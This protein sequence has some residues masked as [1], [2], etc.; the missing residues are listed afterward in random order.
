MSSLYLK[1]LPLLAATVACVVYYLN[2]SA[3]LHGALQHPM[4]RPIIAV[5]GSNGSVGKRVVLRA[6]AHG[7]HVVGID[8]SPVATAD[9]QD[10][11]EHFS[12]I[13][14]DLT[15]YNATLSA[16]A[17]AEAII[18]LAA[19]PQP[20]DYKTNT[21]NTNVVSSYNVLRAAAELGIKRVAQASTVNVVTLVFSQK[22]VL[23]YLPIDEEHL[24]EPDEPYGLSKVIAELQAKSIVRRYPDMRVASIRLHWSVPNRTYAN[25]QADT[26]NAPYDLW[27]YV[28]ED[29]GAEAFMLAV[30]R[31]TDKWPSAAEA[32]FIVAPD[33]MATHETAELIQQH[34]PDVPIKDG[35]KI[36]GRQ[37]LFNCAKAQEL[38]GWVHDPNLLG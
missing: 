16:F 23:Q 27:G 20:R 10:L 21:H 24:T 8:V 9:D 38:L 15:D 14:A 3:L 25:E 37:S 4:T 32:F 6:L 19:V 36:T 29:S 18:H 2:G 5:T 22:P 7:Y 35:Q 17:G 33:T 34:Y 30:T 28:Q 12:F 11:G 13:Q 26:Y 1:L 31:P